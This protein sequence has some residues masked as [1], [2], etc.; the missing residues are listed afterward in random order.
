LQPTD[1]LNREF[2]SGCGNGFSSVV[3]VCVFCVG[4]EL[5]EG[6]IA[7]SEDSFR[8]C[9]S[10]CIWTETSTLRR[11]RLDMECCAVEVK[12]FYLLKFY[13]SPNIMAR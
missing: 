3:F 2:E 13:E 8:L 1:S 9:L 4:I 5:S 7:R 11:T 10:N 12:K 6:I